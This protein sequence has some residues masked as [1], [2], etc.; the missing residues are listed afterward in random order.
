[1]KFHFEL[2]PQEFKSLPRDIF[3]IL[4]AATA[5]VLCISWIGSMSVRNAFQLKGA[6]EEIEKAEGELRDLNKQIGD[7]QPPLPTINSIKSRIDFLNS[8]LDTPASS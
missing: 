3:G 2:L 8:N 5:I 6:Q 7:L 4:L 1:M